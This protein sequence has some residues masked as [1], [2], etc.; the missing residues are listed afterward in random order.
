M[1]YKLN[2]ETGSFEPYFQYGYPDYPDGAL[3]TSAAHLARW[4][5]AFMN[6]GSFDGVRVLE[7]STV[8]ESRRHQ[9]SYDAGWRQGLIWY[10]AAPRGYFRM[11]HTGGDY[12]VSTR[13]FLP[14]RHARGRRHAHELLRRRPAMGRVP[15]DR[16]QAPRGARVATRLELPQ[17]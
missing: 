5:G 1:P 6:H 17:L 11:G 13:M 7:R 3:R 4:L 2:K 16:P 8:R 15:G 9:L 12:G 14:P 10:G